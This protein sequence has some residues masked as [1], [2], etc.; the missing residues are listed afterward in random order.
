MK[1][2]DAFTLGRSLIESILH[3]M[4]GLNEWRRRFVLE[5]FMLFLTIRGRVNFLQLERYGGYDESTY[6]EGFEKKFDFLSFNKM[7]IGQCC[8]EEIILGF[9]PS[10]LSKSGKR[11]PGLGYFYSGCAGSYKR[12][13]EIGV[14]AAIDLDQNTAYHV[15]AIQSPSTSKE[16]RNGHGSEESLVDHYAESIVSRAAD[17]TDISHILAVD[18][19][20]T[21]RKF[22]DRICDET[23]LAIVGRL[24]KDANLRYLHNGTQSGRKGRP[25][26]Y[27]GKINVNQIDRRRIVLSYANERIRIYCAPVNSVGLKRNIKLCYV[28]FLNTGGEIIDTKMYFSTDLKLSGEQIYN[29]YKARYQMEFN[30]RDAKQHT[31]L[32][33]CQARSVNKI[34]Y[35]IN[36]SLTAV[37]VGKAIQRIDVPIGQ[38]MRNSMSD[39]KTEIFNHK[40]MRRIFSIYPNAP[41]I[42]IN[43]YMFWDILD[44]GKIAA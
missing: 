31:G 22:V 10:F 44:F 9:D 29:Y 18:A 2:T 11:T 7:L 35:H 27:D 43:S 24:R 20:F 14:I 39:V 28:E 13:L 5:S 42:K 34:H 16:S 17:L 41:D 1:T 4:D 36:A 37:S 26:Q 8:T 19:Y 25:K 12:G 30:F 23:D 33:H 38:P 32:Q 3:K 21:K 15:E 40:L 6:R